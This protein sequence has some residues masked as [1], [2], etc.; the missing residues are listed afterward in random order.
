MLSA[1]V[2]THF[3]QSGLSKAEIDSGYH[4]A[5]QTEL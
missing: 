3:E 1:P 5:I 4:A 2:S